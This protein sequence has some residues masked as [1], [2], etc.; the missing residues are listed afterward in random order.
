MLWLTFSQ[1]KIH[2]LKRT[3]ANVSLEMTYFRLRN[4]LKAEDPPAFING[5]R[6]S[7]RLFIEIPASNKQDKPVGIQINPAKINGPPIHKPFNFS[8]R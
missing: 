7:D 2:F 6:Q 4:K 3:K 5:L 8:L 1:L